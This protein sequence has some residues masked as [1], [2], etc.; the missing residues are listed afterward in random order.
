MSSV[1]NVIK[2]T[3]VYVLLGTCY[4]DKFLIFLFFEFGIHPFFEAN[5]KHNSGESIPFFVCSTLLVFCVV[6]MMTMKWVFEP[7]WTSSKAEPV[8]LMN[9]G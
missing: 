5:S 9:D 3:N 4:Y 2:M 7:Q 6:T 1:L 8:L